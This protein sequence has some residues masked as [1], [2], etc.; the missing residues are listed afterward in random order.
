M[1]QSLSKAVQQ[2]FDPAFRKVFN[3]SL[4][5]AIA[6][7]V[8]VWL[9]FWAGL[10]WAESW[11]GGWLATADIW[12]WVKE[13]LLWLFNAGVVLA[14]LLGSFFLFPAVLTFAMSFLLEEIAGAVEQRHYPGQPAARSQPLAEAAKGAL[15]FGAM[16]LIANLVLLPLYFI[17]L[18][19]VVVFYGLNGYLLG[20]EYFELVAVRRLELPDAKRLRRGF[21]IRVFIAGIV[22]ALLLTIPI[23]N[24]V[25]PIVATAFMVHVF[26]DLRRR[27]AKV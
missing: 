15:S 13:S 24:L 22:I 21:R 26:Q 18:V 7:F 9:L 16:V 23:V 19:N 20:R 5:A 6:T 10:G 2:S 11:L 12:S 14:V 8:L 25:T 17:P 1:L 4:L 3:R 27:E